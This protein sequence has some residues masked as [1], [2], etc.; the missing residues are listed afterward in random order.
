VAIRP[1]AAKGWAEAG[2]M[3]FKGGDAMEVWAGRR[4]ISQHN[5]SSP[6]M[7]FKAFGN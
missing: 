1:P 7:I 3:D 4:A 6:D 2:I 5:T